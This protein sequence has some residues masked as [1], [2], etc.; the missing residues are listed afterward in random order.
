M[1]SRTTPNDADHVWG[2]RVH[3]VAFTARRGRDRAA[4][5]V[6]A[7]GVE[8]SRHVD[9][10]P[11]D[12]RG[13]PRSP[14]MPGLA[15]AAGRD[16]PFD[17]TFR[18]HPRPGGLKVIPARVGPGYRQRVAHAVLTSA[19]PATTTGRQTQRRVTT[20]RIA[21]TA[22]RAR[23]KWVSRRPRPGWVSTPTSPATACAGSARGPVD[24][25]RPGLRQPAPGAAPATA[26]HAGQRFHFCSDH[27][28]E[29]FE[30]HPDRYVT[31][32]TD[33]DPGYAE[34]GLHAEHSGVHPGPGRR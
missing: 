5:G 22:R 32:A 11:G 3:S 25:A 13:A 16:P 20:S 30:Q 24:Q 7:R 23:V 21:I 6:S 27:C 14:P 15:W 28:R 29:A 33:R 4:P 12:E 26:A 1:A 17:P 31:A 8:Q 19:R 34:P 10:A 9:Q 2:P 18:P